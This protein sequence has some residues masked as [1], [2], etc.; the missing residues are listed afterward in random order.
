[1]A[2]A[3]GAVPLLLALAPVGSSA[4][5]TPARPVGDPRPMTEPRLPAVTCATLHAGLPGGTREFAAADEA[6][7]P[8]TARIQAALDSCAG[9]GGAVRLDPGTGGLTSF[10]SSPLIVR[11]RE[12]LVIGAGVTLFATRDAAAYQQPGKA[13]CGSIGTSGT[14]CNPFISVDGDDAGVEGTV[15]RDARGEHWGTIDG[16]GDETILGTGTSWY[17][18]AATATAEGLKQV[19]PRLIQSNSADDLTIYQVRL[20]NAA[21]QHVFIS[22]SAGATIWGIRI[23]TP[24][25]TY[26][27]DGVDVDSSL[28]VTVADSDLMEGDDCVALTTNSA[29]ESGVTVRGLHCYGTHGLSIGS[30]TA[31]GLDSILFQGNTLDGYDAWGH[32]STLDN[33]IRIK[34]YAGAGGPVTNVVYADTCMRSVQNLI[35]ISPFYDPPTGTS[36][37]WFKSVTVEG[38]R[39]VDSVSGASS[40]IDGYSA[41]YPTGLTLRGVDFDA[42]SVSAQYAN[43]AVSHADLAPAGT[44]V[45]VSPTPGPAPAPPRC[46]FPPF[47]GR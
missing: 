4:A 37:P 46:S 26:N 30:G 43:I 12:Y 45:T 21:K 41:A 10:L 2:A 28:D 25:D 8:D 1:M 23:A 5:G 39:A 40:L 27:T 47:P 14:G 36:I 33:G 6:D 18:N 35:L 42:T 29:A 22:K 15:T 17:E 13:A 44:G 31:Y 16:R 19:N 24:D 20:T 11:S 38:A 3:L 34:S 9:S 7:P 32:L